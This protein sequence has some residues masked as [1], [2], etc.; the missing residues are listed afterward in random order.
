MA[1]RFHGKTVFITGASSGIGAELARQFA[2]EGAKVVAAAR[3]KEKLDELTAGINGAGGNALAVACDV[4]DRASVDAA[5][6]EAVHAFGGL[7][8]VV[9][10]AGFGVSGLMHTLDTEDFRRQFETN[11]FGVVH[12]IY[13]T[14]PHLV[15]SRGRLGLV[16][17][18]MGRFGAP[19][20][21][22][23]CASKFAVVGLAE[24]LYYELAEQGVSVTC[25]N[26]GVV[27]SNI[28]MVDNQNRWKEG[29]RDPAPAWLTVRTDKAC[30]EIVNALYRRKFE[31]VITGH[32]KLACFLARHFPRSFRFAVR[33]ATRGKLDT[34]GKRKRA[35][36]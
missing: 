28:R 35:V 4:A 29:R 23:Y 17:S 24:S 10:N 2:A 26:P 18:I 20:T 11:F 16:A 7:D 21:A 22:A 6:A 34:L 5:V 3:R 30:R 8:V 13:A 9:A 33:R 36:D 31:A 32:G 12:T 15:A 27:E 19:T 14:L 25:I 1:Q